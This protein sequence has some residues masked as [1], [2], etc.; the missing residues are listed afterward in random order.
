MINRQSERNDPANTIF[1][2]FE[3]QADILIHILRTMALL[4]DNYDIVSLYSPKS[5]DACLCKIGNAIIRE[6]A[7]Y[8]Y[9]SPRTRYDYYLH[10]YQPSIDGILTEK[11]SQHLSA[12][13]KREQFE[14]LLEKHGV[15]ARV[16]DIEE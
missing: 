10:R 1:E 3:K 8:F 15:I 6:K 14:K 16:V 4:Q 11:K 2:A 5:R 13:T 12:T 9:R 7:P